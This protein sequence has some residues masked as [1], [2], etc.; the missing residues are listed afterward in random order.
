MHAV[1]IL[2]FLSV[3]LHAIS[4][5]LSSLTEPH[6]FTR[7]FIS[8]SFFVFVY[9][10]PHAILQRKME[11]WRNPRTIRHSESRGYVLGHSEV[12]HLH[13]NLSTDACKLI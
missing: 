1:L 8:A 7:H 12:T 5:L 2:S 10:A 3:G 13:A 4:F 11:L 6:S 9:S